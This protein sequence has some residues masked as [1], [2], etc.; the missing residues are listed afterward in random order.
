M[1][2]E[3]SP[4][5]GTWG[6]RAT[7]KY[8]SSARAMTVGRSRVAAEQFLG[9]GWFLA[10]NESPPPEELEN[11]VNQARA[12]GGGGDSCA[13]GARFVANRSVRPV[14]VRSQPSLGLNLSR[15]FA[16]PSSAWGRGCPVRV[17]SGTAPEDELSCPP[18]PVRD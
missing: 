8:N 7:A 18:G 2:Y 14:M 10:T 12:A 9:P 13:Q 4:A 16:S 11:E 15:C 5:H 1:R 3:V 6:P 17:S